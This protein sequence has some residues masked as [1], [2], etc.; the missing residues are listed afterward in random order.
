M[1]GCVMQSCIDA[2][3]F[4]SLPAITDV[5]IEIGNSPVIPGDSN[6]FVNILI[7]FTDGDGDIGHESSDSISDLFLVNSQI[8][9]F[10]DTLGEFDTTLIDTFISSYLIPFIP[11]NGGVPD[12]T[13]TI[14]VN[15][16]D[17]VKA[18]TTFA[19]FCAISNN[20]PDGIVGGPLT[21]VRYQV[22]FM[23]RDGH[24]TSVVDVPP[25][26]IDCD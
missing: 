7:D 5:R 6:S 20:N 21:E 26:P 2:P 15:V 23:D 25:I 22:W 24:R 11:A 18:P 17:P 3:S 12:I 8:Y 14:K 1:A 4:D 9:F 16:L 13:G 19:G 10:N